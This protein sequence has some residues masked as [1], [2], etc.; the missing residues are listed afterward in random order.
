LLFWL[1]CNQHIAK[2]G[3]FYK[4]YGDF[5]WMMSDLWRIS[6]SYSQE[7]MGL[8]LPEEKNY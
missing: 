1:T 7:M 4:E 5:T 6:G 3:G 2:F 8:I